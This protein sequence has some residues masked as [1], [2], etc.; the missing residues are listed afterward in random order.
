MYPCSQAVFCFLQHALK[1]EQVPGNKATA[2]CIVIMILG[3]NLID[4][5]ACVRVC[6]CV[7]ACACVHLWEGEVSTSL[8]ALYVNLNEAVAP[9]RIIDSSMPPSAVYSSLA[10]SPR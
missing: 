3:K 6:M 2:L 9:V 5:A 10:D 8:I 1:A 4:I 7:R